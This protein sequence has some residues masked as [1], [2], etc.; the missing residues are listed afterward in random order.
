MAAAFEME[1]VT[2]TPSH[3]RGAVGY[4]VAGRGFA[5]NAC[6]TTCVSNLQKLQHGGKIVRE[7]PPYPPLGGNRT[8]PQLL[9]WKSSPKLPPMGGVRLAAKWRGGVSSLMP[10]QLPVFPICNSYCMW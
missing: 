3:G 10:A 8:S 2:K 1:I 6:T 4:E 5:A 7:N 9:R